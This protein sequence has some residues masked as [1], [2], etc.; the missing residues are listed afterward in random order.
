MRRLNLMLLR[1]I[2]TWFSIR[3]SWQPSGVMLGVG[4]MKSPHS[5]QALGSQVTPMTQRMQATLWCSVSDKHK[6]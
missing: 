4:A 6:V 5:L 2:V 3:G 1:V